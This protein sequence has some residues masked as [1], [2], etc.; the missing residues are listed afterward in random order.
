MTWQAV[1]DRIN[2]A[3]RRVFGEPVTYTAPNGSPEAVTG[4]FSNEPVVSESNG[5]GVQTTRPVIDLIASDLAAK[6]VESAA[7]VIRGVTYRV[8]GVEGPDAE[9]I[10]RLALHLQ[11]DA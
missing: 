7:V 3:G 11:L 6:A 8:N 4:V 1:V 5:I 10:V 9:G 2:R